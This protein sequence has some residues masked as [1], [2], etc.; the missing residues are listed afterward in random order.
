MIPEKI[1]EKIELDCM[2][3]RGMWNIQ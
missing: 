1:L 3:K 2:H